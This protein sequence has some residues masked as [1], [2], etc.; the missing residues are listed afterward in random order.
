DMEGWNVLR[1]FWEAIVG[2]A[3][4]LFKNQRQNSLAT[5][6][7]LRGDLTAPQPDVFATIGNVLRH[8]FI[9]AYLPRFEGTQASEYGIEFGPASVEGGDAG[10]AGKPSENPVEK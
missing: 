4:D 8:A 5:V 1:L 9:R 2:G 6:V 3:K 7:P 10:A